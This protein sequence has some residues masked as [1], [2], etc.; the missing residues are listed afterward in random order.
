MDYY[1]VALL[2]A[3]GSPRCT[4][5]LRGDR[6]TYGQ[7]RRC[8]H[9]RR[10]SRVLPPSGA[11]LPAESMATLNGRRSEVLWKKPFAVDVTR[12]VRPGKP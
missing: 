7:V 9:L 3:C 8:F 1:R 5:R 2:A 12:A 10:K 11:M 6:L 4:M